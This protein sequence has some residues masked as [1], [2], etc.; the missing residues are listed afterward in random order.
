MITM[1]KPKVPNT[2]SDKKWDDIRK[3]AGKAEARNGGMFSKKAV[4]Q[5]KLHS[6][7]RS[8]RKAS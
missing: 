2:I 5:R 6:E 1:G 8:K 3:A 7:Q 4:E